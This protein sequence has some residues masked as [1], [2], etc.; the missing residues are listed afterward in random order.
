MIF[1]RAEERHRLLMLP[2]PRYTMTQFTTGPKIRNWGFWY[3]DGWRN[4]SEVTERLPDG[5]SITKE[6]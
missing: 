6:S 1:R 4:A 5:R 2:G 3:P